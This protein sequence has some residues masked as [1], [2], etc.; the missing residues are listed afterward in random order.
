M[1]Q[2]KICMVGAFATGKTSLVAKFV[3]S[4]FSENYQSTVGVKIDKK[5]VNI[6]EKELN[7]ILWDL[8]GED[9]FQKVRLSYLRGSSGYLLVVD[10]T[11]HN[12][13]E[14]AFSLQT[15]VEETIGEVPFILVLNKSDLLDEW[16]IETAEI[17]AIIQRGWTVIQTSAKTGLGVE[18][19]FQTLANQ[20]LEV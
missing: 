7:F 1:L 16:E 20:I 9:E 13:L 12:T 15:R 18:E 3:Y 4:I 10:G 8:Y 5:K 17:D 2:K 6:Q 11:R 19:I 14:K